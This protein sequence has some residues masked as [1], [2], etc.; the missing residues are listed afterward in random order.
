MT[1][2]TLTV[3]VAEDNTPLPPAYPDPLIHEIEIDLE[4]LSM[5][6]A[7]DAI[8][9]AVADQ[10]AADR[11]CDDFHIPAIAAGLRLLFVFEG[12]L[13]KRHHLLEE[14]NGL[15]F[16]QEPITGDTKVWFIAETLQENGEWS[17]GTPDVRSLRACLPNGSPR[18]TRNPEDYGR[19]TLPGALRYSISPRGAEDD[20]AQD[21]AVLRVIASWL[22]EEIGRSDIA[23]IT[24]NA[25]EVEVVFEF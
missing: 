7:Q 3:I 5:D 14:P 9:E 8:R 6:A 12:K 20:P 25:H 19:E 24:T 18:I 1:T 13:P 11:G 2:E 16:Q 10:R 15:S 22:K 17:S 23:S 21:P 4:G